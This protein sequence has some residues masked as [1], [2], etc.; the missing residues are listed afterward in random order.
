MQGSNDESVSLSQ[1]NR[2]QVEGK[3]NYSFKDKS[4]LD[5]S[6]S[7]IINLS[8]IGDAILNILIKRHFLQLLPRSQKALARIRYM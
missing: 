5:K 4:M 1:S 3:L 7:N 8:L 6:V 2:K